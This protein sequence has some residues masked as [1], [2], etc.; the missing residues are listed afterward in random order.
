MT[1]N[2]TIRKAQ[3]EDSK[4]IWIWRND[5]TTRKMS[6]SIDE[7]DWDSH[8]N[9]FEKSLLDKNTLLHIGFLESDKSKVGICRYNIDPEKNVATVSINLNPEKRGRR[10]SCELLSGSM[11]TLFKERKI[12]LAATIKKQ[13]KASITCF[14]KCGFKFDFEDGLY[15]HYVF[16]NVV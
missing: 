6:I 2:I 3:P 15:H 11:R 12:D 13:N 8:S 1:I 5:K 16:H 7:I 10:L 4:D 9:W 14:T